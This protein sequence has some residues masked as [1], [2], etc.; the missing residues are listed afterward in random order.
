MTKMNYPFFPEESN[1]SGRI[2]KV[3]SEDPGAEKIILNH[4][5]EEEKTKK[6]L[7][8]SAKSWDTT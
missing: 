6:L 1:N 2:D 8:T 3:T 5:Q 7:A 4:L